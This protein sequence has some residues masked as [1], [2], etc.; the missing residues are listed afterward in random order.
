MQLDSHNI[1]FNS[2]LLEKSHGGPGLCRL[3]MWHQRD[4]GMGEHT[5]ILMTSGDYRRTGGC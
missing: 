3:V 1:T 2:Q 4:A 5:S